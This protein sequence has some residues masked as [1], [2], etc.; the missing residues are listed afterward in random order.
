MNLLCLTSLTLHNVLMSS[1]LWIV[2]AFHSFSLPNYIPF[3]GYTVFY[4]F[5]QNQSVFGLF[6][7]WMN[8]VAINTHV[9]IFVW[10]YVCWSESLCTPQTHMLKSVLRLDGGIM[11]QNTEVTRSRELRL[12]EGD[13][14]PYFKNSK[15]VPLSLCHVIEDTVTRWPSMNQEVDPH[16]TVCLSG[17]WSRVFPPLEL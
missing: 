3:E 16:Q 17:L 10:I 11:R 12:C 9:P 7:L 14:C 2:Y 8:N 5:M 4:L 15:R 13:P 6:P 1:V